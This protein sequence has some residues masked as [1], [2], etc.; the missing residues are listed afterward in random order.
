MSRR[1][2]SNAASSIHGLAGILVV[3]DN[4]HNVVRSPGEAPGTVADTLLSTAPGGAFGIV[5]A[6][7]LEVVRMSRKGWWP[8]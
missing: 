4:N 7:M 1:E 5:M 2:R 3:F 6:R 8:L